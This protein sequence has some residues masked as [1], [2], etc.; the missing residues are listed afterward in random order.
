VTR[1]EL[2]ELVEHWRAI[3]LPEW[4]I[5]MHDEPWSDADEMDDYWAISRCHD[6][7]ASQKIH[8]P[9][10]SLERHPLDV[11]I[12]VVHELLHALTRPWRVQ[13]NATRSALGQDVHH[14]LY[15]QRE[16]EEEQLVDRL[17]RVLVAQAHGRRPFGTVLSEEAKVPTGIAERQAGAPLMVDASDPRASSASD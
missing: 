14:G 16:H 8:F 15:C 1:A 17:A 9:D 3:L 6:D 10:A 7:Y 12:T 4:R 2:A 11:E 5:E 13:I